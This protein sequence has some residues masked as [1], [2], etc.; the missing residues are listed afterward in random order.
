MLRRRN[1]VISIYNSHTNV[2]SGIKDE[3]NIY[4]RSNYNFK[5][6]SQ[7]KYR[8]LRMEDI[9]IAKEIFT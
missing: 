9:R 3:L 4:N 6:T 8:V 7:W 1:I 2:H 5:S